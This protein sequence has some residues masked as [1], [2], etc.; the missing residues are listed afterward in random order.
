MRGQGCGNCCPGSGFFCPQSSG[1][2]V[3]RRPQ[4]R[5]L[6][7]DY[8]LC[9]RAHPVSQ[10][11][12][13]TIRASNGCNVSTSPTA[14]TWGGRQHHTP[15]H[16]IDQ[17]RWWGANIPL[18]LL[19]RLDIAPFKGAGPETHDGPRSQKTVNSG[20]EAVF[21]K[22]F[23]EDTAW[24]RPAPLPEVAGPQARILQRTVEP[25]IESFV[26]VPMIEVLAP[27]TCGTPGGCG[28]TP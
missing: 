24:W 16:A 15:R 26:L 9:P 12:R 28:L 5:C 18:R 17:F 4:L 1:A 10:H 8:F 13:P 21:F 19:A 23:D 11:S 20:E 2:I 7:W 27:Q 6:V 3:T 14:G 22:L 25:I